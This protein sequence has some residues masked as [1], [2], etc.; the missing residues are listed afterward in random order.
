MLLPLIFSAHGIFMFNFNT[1]I[2]ITTSV[3]LVRFFLPGTG[4]FLVTTFL[5]SEGMNVLWR[6]SP[7]DSWMTLVGIAGHAFIVSA[8]LAASFI[9]YGSGMRWMHDMM[10][11]V[12]A[13]A[14][15]A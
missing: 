13:P 4:I 11:R 10:Q 8:L 5:L 1:V 7:A 6:M 12:A 2:S 3:R 14:V 15:K 9:Y